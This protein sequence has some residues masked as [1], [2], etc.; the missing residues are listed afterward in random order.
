MKIMKFKNL[1]YCG[2]LAGLLLAFGACSSDDPIGGSEITI[3]DDYVLPQKGASDAD[4]ARI[5]ALYDKY[6]AYF[7]YDYT[8]KDV[9]WTQVTGLASNGNR[10]AVANMGNAQNVG[11]MLDYLNEIWFQFFPDEILKKGGIP[12]RVFLADS[13]YMKRDWGDGNIQKFVYPGNFLITGNSIAIGPMDQLATMDAATKKT[14]C[15]SLISGSSGYTGLWDYYIS[16]GIIDV[17][18]EFYS[19]SDY[20]TEPEMTA[21]TSWGNT[22]YSFSAEQLEKYRNRGFLP[23]WSQWGYF[24]EWYYKYSATN[25]NWANAKSLDL[26]CYMGWLF[27]GT[28]EQLQNYCDQ[29]PTVKQ[30]FECLE[31]YYKNKYGIDIRAIAN[32]QFE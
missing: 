27:N 24:S 21:T 20:E 16:Q 14:N 19:Y 30:K 5:K 22:S 15:I 32:Y 11:A 31:N 8:Q 28:D 12:Y 10:V 23:N 29:Y 13:V 2:L 6:G 17:P 26:K 9:S 1:I 18:D 7:L 4:N 25:H 3:E